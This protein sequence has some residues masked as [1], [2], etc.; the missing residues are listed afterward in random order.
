MPNYNDRKG[1]WENGRWVPA[2][3][4]PV[5]L[6]KKLEEELKLDSVITNERLRDFVL[7]Y[8]E[9]VVVETLFNIG[10]YHLTEG[11][12]CKCGIH[13]AEPRHKPHPVAV[14]YGGD[15]V[16]WI[17]EDPEHPGSK[18]YEFR[19]MPTNWEFFSCGQCLTI[20]VPTCPTWTTGWTT[21]PWT[22][23]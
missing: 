14:G 5:E 8:T 3:D 2:P 19:R 22:N 11:L 7:N 9:D 10:R 18:N 6:T 13:R 21:T 17:R 12:Q 1:K 23:C 4:C 16:Q 20:L 15:V